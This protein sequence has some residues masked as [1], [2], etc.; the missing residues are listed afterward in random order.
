MRKLLTAIFAAILVAV[1]GIPMHAQAARVNV[2]VKG[3][4]ATIYWAADNGKKYPFPNINTFYTWFTSNDLRAV[5]KISDK[6]LKAIPNGGNVTYRGGAKLVKFPNEATVYAVSRY[7]TLRPIVSAD[8]AAQI[9]GYNWSGW[10]EN[11]SWSVRGDYTIGS[12]IRQASD[13]SA[14]TE[15]NGVKTPSDNIIRS[16]SDYPYPLLPPFT[17][18]APQATFSGTL[19]LAIGSRSYGPER[20]QLTATLSGSNRDANQVTIQIK[21]QSRN[22]IV[23]TCYA[24]YT[25]TITWYVDTVATQ[26]LVAIAK[27]AAG[28]SLGSNHLN[29]QGLNTNYYDYSYSYPY[30]YY[31]NTTYNY[32]YYSNT[33]YTFAADRSLTAEWTADRTLRLTGKIT[34]Y[35]RPIQNLRMSIIDTSTNQTTKFCDGVDYCM[36]DV[37]TDSNWVN[38]SRYALRVSEVNGQELGYVYANSVGNNTYGTNYT[39]PYDSYY[40]YNSYNYGTPVVTT[41]VARTN[42]SWQYPTV[43]VSSNLSGLTNVSNSR[44]EIYASPVTVGSSNRLIQTCYAAYSCSVQD[45]PWSGEGAPNYFTIFVDGNGA[46]TYSN[47]VN[48]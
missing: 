24:S 7:S 12:T 40:N 3:S 44:L 46:R 2:L 13:Y 45:T 41:Y 23:Q 47:Y 48:I 20:A 26:D 10:V 4:G 27:D 18:N 35:N 11:L 37:R 8:V 16:V 22:E 15:Y 36:I 32:P 39:Y 28:Y 43:M 34:S 42:T 25:C 17:P 19:S 6:E 31:G 29:V 38:S 14:S 1:V 21:N 33:N 5:K 30:N 9:Y